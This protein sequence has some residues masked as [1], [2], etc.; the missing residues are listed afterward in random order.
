MNIESI[1]ENIK[2]LAM[3]EMTENGIHHDDFPD[4]CWEY[5]LEIIKQIKTKLGLEE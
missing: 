3:D 4:R 1:T 5:E 2:G